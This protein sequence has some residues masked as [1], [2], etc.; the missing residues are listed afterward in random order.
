MRKEPTR[1][2]EDY[3]PYERWVN[4]H[5]FASRL[6]G[7]NLISCYKLA[8]KALRRALEDNESEDNMTKRCRIRAA[9]QWMIYSAG[10]L[11]TLMYS[12]P[13]ENDR[14]ELQSWRFTGRDVF[15]VN[16]WNYWKERFV[17]HSTAIGSE[18]I[19]AASSMNRIDRSQ[20]TQGMGALLYSNY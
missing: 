6:Y 7:I 13:T 11:F 12:R 20:P 15:S 10:V 4:L 8:I 5:S 16:R 9:A 18:A 17:Y 19:A 2:E 14:Q 1:Y 3:T